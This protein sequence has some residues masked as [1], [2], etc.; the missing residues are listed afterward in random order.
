MMLFGVVSFWPHVI[1]WPICFE[2]RF[3]ASRKSGTEGG[4]PGGCTPL[5]DS[6]WWPLQLLVEKPWSMPGRSF[7]SFFCTN[8]F[9]KCSFHLVGPPLGVGKVMNPHRM[10]Q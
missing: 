3:Y 4:G 7:V 1:S 8:K 5:A 9:R 2:D 6:A 10:C